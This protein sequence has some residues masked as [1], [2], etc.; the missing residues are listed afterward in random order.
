M[1][2]SLQHAYVIVPFPTGQRI[3]WHRE[4][5][6]HLQPWQL[7]GAPALALA[8]LLPVQLPANIPGKATEDSL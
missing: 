8:A 2:V 7:T 3:M 5:I 4:F 6:W 1:L